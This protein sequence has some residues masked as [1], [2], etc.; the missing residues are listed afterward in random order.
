MKNRSLTLVGVLLFL[1]AIFLAYEKTKIPETKTNKT[2][3]EEVR[4]QYESASETQHQE[5][6]V[7]R[8]EINPTFP[9]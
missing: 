6:F 5:E 2:T 4:F 3:V 9:E 1:L 8:L 7:Y